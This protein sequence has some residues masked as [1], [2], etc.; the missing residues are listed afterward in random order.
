MS[1]KTGLLLV[2]IISGAVVVYNVTTRLSDQTIDVVVGLSCG[3][4]ASVPVTLGLL[5][6]LTRRH[7]EPVKKPEH[8][9]SYP[10]PAAPNSSRQPYPPVIVITPQQGQWP[11]PYGGLP[12]PASLPP[13]YNMNDSPLR[14]DFKIIGEEDDSFD[15]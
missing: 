7:R 4:A 5:I 2:L 15:A 6:A 14:R 9:M 8:V 13:G 10:E 12:Q 1:G 3:L 11:N